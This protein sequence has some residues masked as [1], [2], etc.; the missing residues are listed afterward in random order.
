MPQNQLATF[1]RWRKKLPHNTAY[2][3]D[4]VL[5]EI[6][7][8]F[9]SKG[10]GRFLDYAGG[11]SYA[12]G[13]N[14]IPLQRR[15]GQEWPTVEINFDKRKRPALGI[16]FAMLPEIC[17]RYLPDG[18]TIRIPRI[19]ANVVEGSAFFSLCKGQG[20]NYDGNFGAYWSGVWRSESYFQKEIGAMMV[21]LPWLFDLFDRGIPKT[22]LEASRGG[23]V[24]RHAF[25]NPSS[26][27]LVKKM[28]VSS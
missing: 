10:F 13:A 20:K 6:V 12:V 15:S 1:E 26:Y 21:L 4:L 8:V 9:E 2:L 27:F 5:S 7:P 18:K 25:L 24:D 19:E 3:T 17:H 28:G 23:Y 16:T 14:T 11:S 22:W